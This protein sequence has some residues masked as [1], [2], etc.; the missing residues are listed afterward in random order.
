[1]L[2]AC[3]NGNNGEAS[4][5]GTASGNGAASSGKK[6]EIEFFQ[7]KTEAKETFDK[8]VA[9]FNEAN[10]NIKVTQVNPPDA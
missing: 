10:P 4:N 1:M 6:V 8:L 9:K 3:G 5:S 2:S 7:N